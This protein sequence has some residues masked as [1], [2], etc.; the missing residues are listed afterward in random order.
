MNEGIGL[1]Q[2]CLC[3]RPRAWDNFGTW[4]CE[5]HAGRTPSVAAAVGPDPSESGK[6]TPPQGGSGLMRKPGSDRVKITI[7]MNADALLKA[8]GTIIKWADLNSETTGGDDVE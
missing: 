3:P 1:H 5:M 6:A 8:F 7:T 4:Y 2:C